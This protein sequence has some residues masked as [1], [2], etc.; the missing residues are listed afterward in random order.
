MLTI[1]PALCWTITVSAARD[2]RRLMKKFISSA[3]SKS[4]SVNGEESAQ[5]QTDAADVVHEHVDPAEVDDCPIHETGR[6]RR[7]GQVDRDPP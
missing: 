3:H 5:P 2:D 6:P 1:A 7:R 4:S